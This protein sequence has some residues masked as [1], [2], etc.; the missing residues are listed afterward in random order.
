MYR[1]YDVRMDEVYFIRDYSNF[2]KDKRVYKTDEGK[3]FLMDDKWNVYII[4][5]VK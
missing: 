4:D 1:I 3:M 2:I 5:R